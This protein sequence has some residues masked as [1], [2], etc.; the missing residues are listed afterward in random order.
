MQAISAHMGE[1]LKELAH[2]KN[3]SAKHIADEIGITRA[4]VYD[5]YKRK[6]LST[7][8]LEKYCQIIGVDINEV[9]QVKEESLD[10]IQ[11]KTGSQEKYIQELKATIA[12][13]KKQIDDQAKLLAQL[14]QSNTALIE[15]LGKFNASGLLAVLDA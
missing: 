7:R 5:T 2:K 13:Q 14:A 11:E 6:S 9:I 12:E 8:T 1:R 3:I 4:G 10:I 15:K